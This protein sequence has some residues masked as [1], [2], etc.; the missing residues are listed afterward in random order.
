MAYIK[1]KEVAKHFNFTKALDIKNAPSYI[2]DYVY[3]GETILGLYKV[4]KD[5]GLI[6]DRKI[7][8]FDNSLSMRPKKEITTIS[9]HS[10]SAHSIVFHIKTAEIYLL[11]DSGHPLLLKFSN[12]NDSDKARLRFLYNAMSSAICNQQIPGYVI[13]KLVNNDFHFDK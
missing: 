4:G 11:L 13:E 2:K 3:D 1:Y 12:M 8:L 9:Y 6:T 7:I 10:V 5:H